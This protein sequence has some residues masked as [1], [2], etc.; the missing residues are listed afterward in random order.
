MTDRY[1]IEERVCVSTLSMPSVGVTFWEALDLA[2]EAGFGGIEI[3]PADFQGNTR[4][5]RTIVSVG[6][7]MRI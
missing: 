4:F 5:P 2:F 1:A 3:V 7:D 6:E